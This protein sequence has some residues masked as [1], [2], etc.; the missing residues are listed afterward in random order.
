M[1]GRDSD[2]CPWA[3]CAAR[4]ATFACRP[5]GGTG[6]TSG[7]EDLRVTV[8]DRDRLRLTIAIAFVM[9]IPPGSRPMTGA[10]ALPIP[11]PLPGGMQ[12]S[13]SSC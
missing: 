5:G 8:S 12:S 4:L 1:A 2:R 13:R 10:L 3:V 9:A 11:E 6:V 7:V